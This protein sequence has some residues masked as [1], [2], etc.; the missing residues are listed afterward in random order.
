MDSREWVPVTGSF[1][2]Q[3]NGEV[4]RYTGMRGMESSKK[5]ELMYTA[6]VYRSEAIGT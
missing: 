2:G 6:P 4:R 3:A 1:F 5:G